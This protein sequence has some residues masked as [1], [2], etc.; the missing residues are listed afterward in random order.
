[1]SILFFYRRL[2]VVD[3]SNAKDPLNIVYVGLITVVTLWIVGFCL[4]FIFMCKDHPSTWFIPSLSAWDQCVNIDELYVVYAIS[5]FVADVI[6]IFLPIPSVRHNDDFALRAK[7]S[8]Q[9]CGPASSDAPKD[10][11]A[12]GISSRNT[13]R[14]AIS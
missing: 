8:I 7:L 10:W 12:A 5:D 11:F 1:L 6:I 14:Y 4:A 13:V 3:K 2:F 9:G